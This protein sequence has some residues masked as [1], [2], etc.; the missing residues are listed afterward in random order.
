MSH[1]VL[2]PGQSGPQS[3]PLPQEVMAHGRGRLFVDLGANQ[4]QV[5]GNGSPGGANL[6]VFSP[7]DSV[8]AARLGMQVLAFAQRTIDMTERT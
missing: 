2:S 3:S 1:E 5:C 7:Q 6:R 4:G 8:V